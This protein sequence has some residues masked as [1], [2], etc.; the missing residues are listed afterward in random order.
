MLDHERNARAQRAACRRV[1]C[2][3]EIGLLEIFRE[4]GVYA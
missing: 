3:Q 1:E 2:A 4:L